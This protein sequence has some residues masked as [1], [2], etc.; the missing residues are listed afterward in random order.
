[1]RD[2]LRDKQ[3]QFNTVDTSHNYVLDA[4]RFTSYPI[5]IKNIFTSVG[6]NSARNESIQSLLHS[7]MARANRTGT[8]RM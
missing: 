8:L 3:R 5:L 2:E 4:R 7:S 6:L 1:M